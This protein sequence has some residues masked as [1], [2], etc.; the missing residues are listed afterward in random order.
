[1]KN[2]EIEKLLVNVSEILTMLGAVNINREAIA[3]HAATLKAARTKLDKLQKI[4][5]D[6]EAWKV[7]SPEEQRV[8]MTNAQNFYPVHQE[9]VKELDYLDMSK[10]PMLVSS[11][12]NS[13]NHAF[14]LLEWLSEEVGK[15]GRTI[16]PHLISLRAS[17]FD[18]GKYKNQIDS[19]Y[20][21]LEAVGHDFYVEHVVG[22][23]QLMLI[24]ICNHLVVAACFLQKE[25]QRLLTEDLPEIK[26]IKLPEEVK[27]EIPGS[28]EKEFKDKMEI[29]K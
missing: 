21:E 13:L 15:S 3:T 22:T 7:L 16:L 17:T 18:K 4:R 12:V 1:M 11:A 19:L 25:K 6:E 29:V 10:Q 5:Q 2:F 9:L 26:I 20:S 27:P 23:D 14:L 24:P 28:P 8:M